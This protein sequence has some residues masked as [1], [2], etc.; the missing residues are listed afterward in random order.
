MAP[1][2]EC[3]GWRSWHPKGVPTPVKEPHGIWEPSMELSRAP[4]PLQSHLSQVYRRPAA[5]HIFWVNEWII[6]CHHLNTLLHA[7]A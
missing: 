4:S 1:S 5:H 6:H 7:G 2:L 3:H